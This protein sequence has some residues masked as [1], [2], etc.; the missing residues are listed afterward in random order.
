M[1]VLMYHEVG[2]APG[3]RSIYAMDRGRFAAHAEWLAAR[4]ADG[5]AARRA[6]DEVAAGLAITFDDGYADALEIAAPL[7]AARRLPFTVFVT[8]GHVESGDRRYLSPAG[9]RELA[10]AGA[11]IGSHGRRHVPL[12]SC[13]DGELDDELRGS[14]EWLEA[15]LGRAVTT[16]SYPHG[17]VDARVRGAAARAGYAVAYTSRF[18]PVP[19]GGDDLAR[20]RVDVWARDGVG[21]LG[22]KLAGHW[23]WMAART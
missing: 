9:L 7:L 5:W 13:T 8:R 17:A 21:T 10:A 20:P 11:T 4:V 23:D 15:A 6:E 3:G 18:G 1:R 2:A 14:R 12:T 16:M 19:A 22:A